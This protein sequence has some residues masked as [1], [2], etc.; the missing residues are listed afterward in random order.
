MPAGP[1]PAMQQR[2]AI[3]AASIDH[4]PNLPSR[5]ARS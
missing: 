4:P 3:S 5:A 2:T 1:P